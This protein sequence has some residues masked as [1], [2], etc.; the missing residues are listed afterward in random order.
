VDDF[1]GQVRALCDFLGVQWKQELRDFDAKALERGRIN[2]P[3]Y[4]QV[5]QPIYRQARYRWERYREQLA[6]YLPTLQ[7]YVERFGYA[8]DLPAAA[9]RVG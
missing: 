4:E 5:S 3:S 8:I 7:P 6:P 2:T 1:D 9:D